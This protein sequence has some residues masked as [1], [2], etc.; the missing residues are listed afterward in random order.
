MV[1]KTVNTAAVTVKRS[2][3]AIETTNRCTL[4][5]RKWT[6]NRHRSCRLPC[7]QNA[8]SGFFDRYVAPLS[9]HRRVN[10][11]RCV[12]CECSYTAVRMAVTVDVA[13]VA[14]QKK[15]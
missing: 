9:S 12:V 11:S 2:N 14:I 6:I 15:T 10:R 5:I 8:R 7:F 3:V 4:E 13:N 1:H